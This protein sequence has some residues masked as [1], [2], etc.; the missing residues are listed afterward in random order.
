MQNFHHFWDASFLNPPLVSLYTFSR[1]LRGKSP[2]EILRRFPDRN[3]TDGRLYDSQ[4]ALSTL[5][6]SCVKKLRFFSSQKIHFLIGQL[7][8]YSSSLSSRVCT[9]GSALK[10]SW[11]S[12]VCLTQTLSNGQISWSWTV[13]LLRSP[14]GETGMREPFKPKILFVL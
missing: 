12:A 7:L 2:H 11:T 10:K 1:S 14:D 4:D 3:V 8:T 13:M 5:V 9:A 6:L